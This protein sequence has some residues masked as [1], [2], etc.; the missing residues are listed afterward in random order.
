MTNEKHNQWKV[1]EFTSRIKYHWLLHAAPFCA[2]FGSCRGCHQVLTGV[3]LCTFLIQ[4]KAN[5][6]IDENKCHCEFLLRHRLRGKAPPLR[7]NRTCTSQTFTALNAQNVPTSQIYT[8]Q[9]RVRRRC[10]RCP[11]CRC[12]AGVTVHFT[13]RGQNDRHVSGGRTLRPSP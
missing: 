6:P 10:C 2:V 13:V 1:L 5:R 11:S 9:L 3:L 7:R 4:G 12:C 8:K